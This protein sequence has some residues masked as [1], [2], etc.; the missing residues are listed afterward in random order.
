MIDPHTV[1][2]VCVYE[3]YREKTGDNTPSVI[4]STASPYKFTG[5]VMSALGEEYEDPADL[6][7]AER[8]CALSGVEI[9]EAIEEIRTAPVLHTR[10]CG[11]EDMKK[12][13]KEILGI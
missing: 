5:S 11:K 1:V 4:V 12:T 3:K 8:L 9:P 10:V 6:S 2:A 13:V 7:L